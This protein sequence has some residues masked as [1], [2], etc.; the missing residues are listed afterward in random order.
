M[1][2]LGNSIIAKTIDNVY[3]TY[4]CSNCWTRYNKDGEPA[5]TAKRKIHK[6]GSEGNLDN[7]VENRNSHCMK[8]NKEINIHITDNTFRKSISEAS[9]AKEIR[10][11][12]IDE[13]IEQIRKNN[14]IFIED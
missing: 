1:E 9:K 14:K 3:F 12:R 5:K 6:H 13:K 2:S 7:R 10:Q 4:E 11:K 8:N